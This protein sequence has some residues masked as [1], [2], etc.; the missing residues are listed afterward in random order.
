MATLR[1]H[2]CCYA[3]S[4]KIIESNVIY[5]LKLL[6]CEQKPNRA[7]PYFKENMFSCSCVLLLLQ[8]DRSDWLWLRQR[9]LV[10]IQPQLHAAIISCVATKLNFEIGRPTAD[11]CK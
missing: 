9:Q 10:L 2:K 3:T 5:H 6:S 4:G 1:G 8:T 7:L 11:V